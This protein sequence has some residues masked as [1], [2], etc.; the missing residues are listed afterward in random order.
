M[1]DVIAPLALGAGI[2]AFAGIAAAIV[3]ALAIAELARE[4]RRWQPALRRAVSFTRSSALPFSV[5]RSLAP[6]CGRNRVAVA[7]AV[8]AVARVCVATASKPL[9]FY[10]N[11]DVAVAAVA[12]VAKIPLLSSAGEGVCLAESSCVGGVTTP[13]VVTSPSDTHDSARVATHRLPESAA[14]AR[15]LANSSCASMTYANV[16][17]S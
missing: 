9:I 8:D 11:V 3:C 6:R 13:S 10:A 14:A 7:N 2:A 17:S 1:L 15:A 12:A 16:T 5:R 4:S